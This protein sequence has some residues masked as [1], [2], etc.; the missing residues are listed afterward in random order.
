MVIS[1]WFL[2]LYLGNFVADLMLD[3]LR[4]LRLLRLLDRKVLLLLLDRL[5]LLDRFAVRKWIVW[6]TVFD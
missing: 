4:G 5:W 6:E 3:W 1:F 2:V